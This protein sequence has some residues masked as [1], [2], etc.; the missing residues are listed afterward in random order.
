[1]HAWSTEK[2]IP[3]RNVRKVRKGKAVAL[4]V[5]VLIFLFVVMASV[6]VVMDQTGVGVVKILEKVQN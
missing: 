5:F 1:M 2:D 6:V 4:A 3:L